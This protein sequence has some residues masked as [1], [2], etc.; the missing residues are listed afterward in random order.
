[1]ENNNNLKGWVMNKCGILSAAALTI[2]AVAFAAPAHAVN[3]DF[4]LT[5]G[6]LTV[7]GEIFGLASSG[8]S[9][10]TSVVVDTVTSSYVIG[11]NS[12]Y[13]FPFTLPSAFVDPG[14]DTFTVVGGE[15][16]VPNY[17]L[18]RPNMYPNMFPNGAG[19]GIVLELLSNASL[20]QLEENSGIVGTATFSAV[21]AVPE[22]STWA[23]M[24]FGFA[25]VGFM[26]YRRKAK[27]AP[28]V[29]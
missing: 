22:P 14:H 19:G 1:L 8:T 3:F 24:L 9:S 23:M 2:T 29:A 18:D 4:M 7:T 25:G 10:P 15:I 21:A 13:T 11:T 20:F 17:F 28:M 26:A 5:E 27:S 6:N 12:P 16:S